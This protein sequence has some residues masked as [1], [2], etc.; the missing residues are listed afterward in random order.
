MLLQVSME[1]RI[2]AHSVA[3]IDGIS[4]PRGFG[5]KYRWN[6]ASLLF[7]NFGFAGTDLMSFPHDFWNL[8]FSRTFGLWISTEMLRLHGFLGFFEPLKFGLWISTEMLRLH[9]FGFWKCRT[10]LIC[11]RFVRVSTKRRFLAVFFFE[12]PFFFC[13][14][15]RGS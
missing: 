2:L 9:I 5:C 13:L 14:K 11:F 8:W 1:C 10:W 4:H 15:T 7:K 12:K 3:S 6:V